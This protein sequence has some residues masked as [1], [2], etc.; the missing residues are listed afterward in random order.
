MLSAT[1][2]VLCVLFLDETLVNRKA[3]KDPL[4]GRESRIL[5][6]F[7]VEQRRKNLI[8]NALSQ[9]LLQLVTAIT[10]PPVFLNSA[11]YMLVFA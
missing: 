3:T 2:W 6:L 8:G 7:G 10:K 4:A 5:R 11:Y 9:A 1:C